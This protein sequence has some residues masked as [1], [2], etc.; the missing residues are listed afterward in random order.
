LDSSESTSI[1]SSNIKVKVS[2]SSTSEI[3]SPRAVTP[4]GDITDNTFDFNKSS[5]KS[6]CTIVSR[7]I[8]HHEPEVAEGRTIFGI[9]TPL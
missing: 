7:D 9:L 2:S 8:R 4:L 6:M 1:T 3:L 5:E